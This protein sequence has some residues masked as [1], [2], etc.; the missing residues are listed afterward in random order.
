MY[1]IM[2]GNIM[3]SG[4]GLN[5]PKPI[6]TVMISGFQQIKQVVFKDWAQSLLS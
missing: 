5:M 1:C 6:A 2:F 4:A 3:Q